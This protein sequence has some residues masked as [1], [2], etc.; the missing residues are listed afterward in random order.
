MKIKLTLRFQSWVKKIKSALYKM[1][2]KSVAFLFVCSLIGFMVKLPRVFHHYDKVLHALFYFAAAFVLNFIY[3]KRWYL[4]TAGLFFF[5]VM[6]EFLQEF[7]NKIVGKTIHG[8][9]DIQDV[10][11]NTIGLFIGTLSFFA[12]QF[13]IKILSVRNKNIDA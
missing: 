5:G 7:S 4:I 9:F 6:I 10:K 1:K 3:P 13:M 11:Y 2:S 12:I 8:R